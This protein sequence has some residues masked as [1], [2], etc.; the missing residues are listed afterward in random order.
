MGL[1]HDARFSR[2][3]RAAERAQASWQRLKTSYQA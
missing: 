3:Q 2:D 1:L